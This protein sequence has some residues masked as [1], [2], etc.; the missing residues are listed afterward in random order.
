MRLEFVNLVDV[1]YSLRT[2][3]LK[4]TCN[5][6]ANWFRSIN[7]YNIFRFKNTFGEWSIDLIIKVENF[8]TL[9]SVKMSHDNIVEVFF[10][11]I[12]SLNFFHGYL[13]IKMQQPIVLTSY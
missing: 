4:W 9:K 11:K 2:L 8:I 10:L 12:K 6:L 13:S 5:M 3:D 7:F 1:E